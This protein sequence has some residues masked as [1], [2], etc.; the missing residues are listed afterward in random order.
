MR[1]EFFA[2]AAAIFWSLGSA[3]GKK[4]M[5]MAGLSPELGLFLR[6][7]LSALLVFLLV[8]PKITQYGES[9]ASPV[10]RKGIL[11]VLVFEGVL[12]GTLGMLAFYT[13]IRRGEL[14]RVVP[15]AFTTPL[16]GFLWGI[17]LQGERVTALKAGG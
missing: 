16:W 11:W 1:P 13:A 10:G 5:A 12:A 14:S 17:A 8:L 4:G 9:W 7:G 6:L 3:F 2:L 15:L